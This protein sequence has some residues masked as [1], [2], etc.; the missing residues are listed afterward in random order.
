MEWEVRCLNSA[1]E[2]DDVSFRAEFGRQIQ[3]AVAIRAA[4][5]EEWTVYESKKNTTDYLW[6][7][8]YDSLVWLLFEGRQVSEKLIRFAKQASEKG[9]LERADQVLQT[10]GKLDE[11]LAQL[12]KIF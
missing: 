10:A 6:K 12:A 11:T 7:A 1:F 8:H 4:A 9:L 5:A 3:Q 2:D